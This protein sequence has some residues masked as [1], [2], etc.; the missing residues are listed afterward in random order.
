MQSTL[1]MD[2]GK[3]AHRPW[4]GLGLFG[5]EYSKLVLE[6]AGVGHP[7][8]DPM[9]SFACEAPGT[10]NQ[11]SGAEVYYFA[12]VVFMFTVFMKNKCMRGSLESILIECAK[13]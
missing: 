9:D 5:Q 2:P 4:K 11:V 10:L 12:Y 3:R 7:H 6:G 1:R 13:V 8:L